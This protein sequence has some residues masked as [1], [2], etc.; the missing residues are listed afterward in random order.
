[1]QSFSKSVKKFYQNCEIPIDFIKLKRYNY[2][3]FAEINRISV[4]N[5][6]FLEVPL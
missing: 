4:C 1:M 3:I 6:I 2:V 5:S